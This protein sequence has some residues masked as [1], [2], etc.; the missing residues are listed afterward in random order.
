MQPDREEMLALVERTLGEALPAA[1]ERPAALV[2]AMRYAVSSGGKRLRPLVCLGAAHAAG[3]D[4]RDA[5]HAAAAI[6]LLHTYTLV[7]DDLPE[8]D[9]DELRR[10]K[11]TVWKKF[12]HANA[13]LAGDALQA[14]AF[15]AAAKAP[16]NA[17]AVLAAL[18][19]A[20]YGV[21]AGQVEDLQRE[22]ALPGEADIGFIY[23]H[24][25]ADLFV[26]AAV[27][28]GLAAGAGETAVAALASYGRNLG[29][30]FQ[31]EDD[32][33]DGDSPYSR[34]ETERLVR[35]H[36]KAAADALAGLDGDPSFL[37][38]LVNSLVG[39]KV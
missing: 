26:A 11:P 5:R 18:S 20:A 32:L 29:L 14:L 9:N 3:G 2:E 6:E 31:Y 33:L 28:G 12:G 15:A 36:T 23:D 34:E 19:K 8:M 10:G 13:V 25:T 16:R 27:M 17:S 39:R 24:K 37:A 35:S 4:W 30:A 21:V 38:N 7:H 1:G 22:T